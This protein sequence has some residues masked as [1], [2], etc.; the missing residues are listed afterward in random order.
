LS[1]LLAALLLLWSWGALLSPD[2]LPTVNGNENHH[3]AG[4]L[5]GHELT[6]RLVAGEGRWSPENGRGALVPIAAFAEEGQAPSNP[7]PLIRVPEGTTIHLVVRNALDSS[8]VIHGL[9][10]RPGDV[11][12]TLMVPAGATREIRFPAGQPGTYLYWASITGA[13]SL[14]KREG[15][16]SQLNGA[17]IVDPPGA[18]PDDH[19]MV[20]GVWLDS[21]DIGGHRDEYESPVINGRSFPFTEPENLTVGDSVHWRVINASDRAHPM[22]LH[23]FFFRVLARGDV[24][25]DTVIAPD[26]RWLAVTEHVPPGGTVRMEWSP[27][28][29]GN[30]IFHCHIVYHILWH[31]THLPRSAADTVPPDDMPMAG[32]IIPLH[33]RPDPN[34]PVAAAPTDTQTVRL[35]IQR[36]DSVWDS[37]PGLGYV[38]QQGNRPPAPDS[39]DIPGSPLVLTRGRFARIEVVNHLKE[40]TVVHWHG[41]EIHSYY[42][43]V[44]AVSGWGRHLAPPIAAGDSF[45][46]EMTP[47]RAG[48]F[49]YHTHLDDLWQLGHGLYGPLIVL[50]PGEHYDPA[51]DHVI[52]F[53]FLTPE[54]LENLLV[55]GHRH[56]RSLVFQAGVPQRLRFISMPTAGDVQYRLLDADSSLVDWQPVAK[57]GADLPPADRTPGPAR[58]NID[59]GETYDFA[60]T[61]RHPG[62]MRLELRSGDGKFLARTIP[63]E[64]R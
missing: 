22:H 63:I 48:T 56:P 15:Y 3:P 40:G 29:P 19:V 7:G 37:L 51:T 4:H 46:V 16:D 42:D 26:R 47:P 53:S 8:L 54:T 9:D 24:E 23:G 1:S 33:I 34:A 55:N 36:R 41:M 38:V 52:F 61:P 44:P 17:F 59:V 39:V 20:L 2:S 11:S 60:Y 12:D 49:I 27:D 31:T 30:W 6:L 28:R 32:M 57:D 35:V 10:T 14:Q 62:P 13:E 58:F 25:R 43:G 18:V 5:A 64:V 45:V 21:L 50:K